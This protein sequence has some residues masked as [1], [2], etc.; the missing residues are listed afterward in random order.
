MGGNR[1]KICKMCFCVSYLNNFESSKL[2]VNKKFCTIWN[3][4]FFF[5][6]AMGIISIFK[7]FIHSRFSVKTNSSFG[8]CASS[9]KFRVKTLC[10]R[11]VCRTFHG[12]SM[13]SYLLIPICERLS[14]TDRENG[15]NS[16]LFV[17]WHSKH[18]CHFRVFQFPHPYSYFLI[19]F[20]CNSISKTKIWSSSQIYIDI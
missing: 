15:V 16:K 20:R 4:N 14:R 8:W 19:Y 3:R 9:F 11:I 6:N 7:A 17:I 18:V 13:Y 10:H 2:R 12:W 1:W 5:G